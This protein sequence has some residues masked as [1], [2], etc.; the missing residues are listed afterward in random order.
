MECHCGNCGTPKIGKYSETLKEM[1]F[2]TPDT[3]SKSKLL[4]CIE[5]TCVKSKTQ[6]RVVRITKTVVFLFS[7]LGK[8]EEVGYVMRTEEAKQLRNV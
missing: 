3:S 1:N 4:V 2:N 5:A 6:R 8:V 7:S